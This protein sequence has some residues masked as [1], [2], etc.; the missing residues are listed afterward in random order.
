MREWMKMLVALSVIC[1]LSGLVLATLKQATKGLIEDQV[2]TYVQGPSIARVLTG[3]T[4]NPV[5]DRKTFTD[6]ETQE[7]VTVFPAVDHGR[8][9][10]V[11]LEEFGDGYGGE[12]GVMVG[13]NMDA[14]TLAGISIT[15]MKET[16][17][18]GSKVAK[19]GFTRQFQ[20]HPLD[21]LNLQSKGG[22]IDAV[23]GASYSSA[24]TMQAVQKA[25][26]VFKRIKPQIIKA[27][28]S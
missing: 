19:H 11:A 7:K 25:L 5:M 1:T 16:P 21:K 27:W 17:G 12:I 3:F 15:T 18:I 20:G 6:P 26:S 2:L 13:F 8:L 23:S 24:G 22:D 14:N 4:N 10:S 9:K 28:E